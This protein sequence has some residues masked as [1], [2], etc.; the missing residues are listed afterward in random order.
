MY[1]QVLRCLPIF[2]V[3]II[4]DVFKERLF[5]LYIIASLRVSFFVMICYTCINYLH[6]SL[7]TQACYWVFF[8][9]IESIFFIL[10]PRSIYDFSIPV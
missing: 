8:L 6:L 4:L 7:F 2:Y 10:L 5:R 1:G 9:T 3:I